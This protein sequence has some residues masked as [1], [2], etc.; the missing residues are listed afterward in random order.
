MAGATQPRFRVSGAPGLPRV[1][2]AD[3]Y[4][5]DSPQAAATGDLLHT[6]RTRVIPTSERGSGL[7]VLVGGQTASAD[8]FAAVISRKLPLFL[9]GIVLLSFLILMTVF[10]SLLIRP[11]RRS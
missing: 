2:L 1:A 10:R 8:D 5:R 11:S 9:G 6:V 4:P 3:V 7:R